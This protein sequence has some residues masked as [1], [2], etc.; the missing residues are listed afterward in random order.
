MQ[1]GQSRDTNNIEHKIQNKD[2][3]MK[4]TTQK[5]K[6]ICNSNQKKKEKKKRKSRWS[7]KLSLCALEG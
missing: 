5:T 3:Q 1:N 6:N 7:Q 4:Y 2:K